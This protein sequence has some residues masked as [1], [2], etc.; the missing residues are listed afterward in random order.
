MD[1]AAKSAALYTL[2]GKDGAVLQEK[3]NEL[4]ALH[5]EELA[6]Q[7]ESF[8]TQ[9]ADLNE[10]HAEA[11]SAVGAGT[12]ALRAEIDLQKAQL[13]EAQVRCADTVKQL[14]D[15]HAK[16]LKALQAE[17]DGTLQAKSG[18]VTDLLRAQHADELTAL[19]ALVQSRATEISSLQETLSECRSSKV[20][21]QLQV[22]DLQGQVAALR[23]SVQISGDLEATSSRYQGQVASLTT[24]NDLLKVQVLELT[25]ARENFAG[26]LQQLRDA[27]DRATAHYTTQESEYQRVRSALSTAEFDVGRL[28]SEVQTLTATATAREDEH[29]SA[30]NRLGSELAQARADLTAAGQREASA[31]QKI[32][33]LEATLA[34]V[35]LELRDAQSGVQ[36]F[37]RLNKAAA[38]IVKHI[39]EKV[40]VQPTVINPIMLEIEETGKLN[41]LDRLLVVLRSEASGGAGSASCSLM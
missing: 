20:T 32:A 15:E 4:Q 37:F 40:G 27:S 19:R 39:L 10:K 1:L 35:R 21:L 30:A 12:L 36:D 26:Q 17:F 23:S 13:E 33:Q 34:T 5:M 18:E 6:K 9:N 14:G 38:K 41:K 11:I 28:Q 16:Q 8:E 22:D 2:S 7:K 3:L 29:R 24:E 31:V 25:R